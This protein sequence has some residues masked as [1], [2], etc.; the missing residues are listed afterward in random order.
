MLKGDD[1]VGKAVLVYPTA[2]EIY[3]VQD[4]IFD[5]QRSQVIAFVV[6]AVGWRN[7]AKVLP[8][9]G[10]QA[11]T[12]DAVVARSKNMIVEA[13]QLFEI[14]QILQRDNINKGTP[15][16]TTDGDN[17][18]MVT[19]FYFDARTGAIEGY[20][21]SGGMFADPKTGRSFL[22][23]PG[24]LK[25]EEDTALVPPK[26]IELMKERGNRLSKPDDTNA[27]TGPAPPRSWRQ[28][29][30]ASGG[31]W[32]DISTVSN[33]RE[34]Y[35][36]PHLRENGTL[37]E[38][39]QGRRVHHPVRAENGSLVAA[40]GQIVTP[41]VIERARFYKKERELLKAVGLELENGSRTSPEKD[42]S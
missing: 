12:P 23:V 40:Q 41:K 38:R 39:T 31:N 9:S 37:V 28:I 27:D 21:V 5:Y 34:N 4:L 25:L 29:K 22:P 16:R 20:E 14:K 30:Q 33:Q 19:D 6:D 10:V 2:E 11:V 18:G 26:I 36:K 35:Q 13:R 42:S 32:Q 3:K 24:M 8:W 1:I 15:V 7:E 17:L